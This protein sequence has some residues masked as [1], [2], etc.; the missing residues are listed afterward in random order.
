MTK[1][2]LSASIAFFMAGTTYAAHATCDI[3]KETHS[4]KSSATVDANFNEVTTATLSNGKT[5]EFSL[6]TVKVNPDSSIEEIEIDG[7]SFH[8]CDHEY[9]FSATT[10]ANNGVSAVC[11]D[12]K[13]IVSISCI[14]NE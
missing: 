10:G 7:Y 12:K 14:Y 2:L 6:T 9:L 8:Q 3:T 11:M 5:Q 13:A 4:T 1:L